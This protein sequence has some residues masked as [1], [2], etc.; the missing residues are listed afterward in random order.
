MKT[1]SSRAEVESPQTPPDHER[2]FS[3]ER[4]EHQLDEQLEDFKLKWALADNVIEKLRELPQEVIDKVVADFHPP[5][6]CTDHS[7]KCVG[8]M[9]SRAEAFGVK[10]RLQKD[11]CGMREGDW[12]CAAC[13]DHNFARNTECRKC[14][15]PKPDDV[16]HDFQTKWGL[17]DN[18]I[19]RLQELPQEVIDRIVADFKPLPDCTD[20][21]AKC[22][23]FMKSRAPGHFDTRGGDLKRPQ[24]ESRSSDF[25]Q[26]WESE[27]PD[28]L[29]DFQM[30]WG[31]A[32]NV[33]QKLQ[34]LP[35]EVIDSVVAEFKPPADCTD[36]SAK[37]VGFMKSRTGMVAYNPRG[38]ETDWTRSDDVKRSQ[39]EYRSVDDFAKDWELDRH[40]AKKLSELPWDVQQDVMSNFS[41]KPG[42]SNISSFF[43]AYMKKKVPYH[44]PEPD[45]IDAFGQQW[46]LSEDC[47]QKLRDAPEEVQ[48]KCMDIFNPRD[49]GGDVSGRF[50]T[51][52]TL[53]ID[54]AAS[55]GNNAWK[56]GSSWQYRH[57][58]DKAAEAAPNTNRVHSRDELESFAFKWG[59]DDAAMER[60]RA[61]PWEDQKHAMA[62]FAPREGG[63]VNAKFVAFLR[64]RKPR[65][66][67]HAERPRSDGYAERPRSE[68]Y[69]DRSRD[70]GYAERPRSDGYAERPRN[71]KSDGYVER[72]RSHGW[73]SSGYDK[74]DPGW[75]SDGYDKQDSAPWKRARR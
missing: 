68:G 51:F 32:D 15:A 4:P 6:E 3:E 59:L 66:D 50:M 25:A 5:A 30:K 58:P 19:Q 16:L 12:I 54:R 63:G 42:L 64:S 11:S 35:Q 74:Q 21:N 27:R 69:A 48:K 31:L 17:A 9:K 44:E 71:I 70:D 52:L 37:C 62:S 61:L 60:L 2:S 57:D 55:A 1:R 75:R 13:G 38:D 65:S 47:L 14:G 10:M 43:M 39:R 67:G 53:Q 40:A 26:K 45:L 23:G 8:F 46:G 56:H 22:M 36:H 28:Q 49:Q 34:E 73:Q 7:S 29:R 20:N 24:T 18:V 33:I 41:P 72:S